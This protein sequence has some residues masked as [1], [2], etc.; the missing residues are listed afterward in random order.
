[1]RLVCK[2][3]GSLVYGGEWAGEKESSLLTVYNAIG[4]QVHT[5]GHWACSD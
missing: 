1:M 2:G 3:H 4:I 5:V